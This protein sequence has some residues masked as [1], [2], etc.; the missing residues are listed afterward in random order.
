MW[1]SKA[2]AENNDFKCSAIE[3]GWDKHFKGWEYPKVYEWL[4]NLQFQYDNYLIKVMDFGCGFSPFPQ[5]IAQHFG[6]AYGVDQINKDPLLVYT[7]NRAYPD[8]HYHDDIFKLDE[9]FD[10]IISCSVLEHL[11]DEDER[12]RIYQRMKEMLNPGG[13][14]CH[15]AD[16]FFPKKMKVKKPGR[17]VNFA[18][19]ANTFGISYDPK[20][21]PSAKGFDFEKIR[22]DIDFLFPNKL[23]ARIMVAHDI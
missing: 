5:F 11:E 9:K 6:R 21:C 22:H 19:L 23:E 14:V 16:Y 4:E 20:M 17:E 2:E 7:L 3:I 1:E 15:I 12:L 18:T 13:K 8:V 10:A